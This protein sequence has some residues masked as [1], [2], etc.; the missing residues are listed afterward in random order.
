M[1]R[2]YRIPVAANPRRPL[3]RRRR[4]RAALQVARRVRRGCLGVHPRCRRPDSAARR[5]TGHTPQEP[6]SPLPY[7]SS[8][9]APGSWRR[10][11]VLVPGFGLGPARTPGG[12]TGC[13]TRHAF[14]PDSR[15]RQSPGVTCLV[16]GMLG[17]AR[18]HSRARRGVADPIPGV[19]RSFPAPWEQN[20][21]QTPGTGG[22]TVSR[23]PLLGSMSVTVR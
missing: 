15:V 2:P 6:R 10:Q 18:E 4:V 12:P 7:G 22:T 19:D 11:R 16:R 23:D 14:Q 5:R 1:F 20:P 8:S 13:T 17:T 9:T 21:R 3:V